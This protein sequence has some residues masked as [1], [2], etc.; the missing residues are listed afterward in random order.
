WHLAE[1]CFKCLPTFVQL[2]LLQY[3]NIFEH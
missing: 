3:Q 2:D 1:E